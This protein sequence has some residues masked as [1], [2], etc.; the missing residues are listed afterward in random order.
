MGQIFSDIPQAIENSL[1][2][3]DK[4]STPSL[5]RDILLPIYQLPENFLVNALFSRWEQLLERVLPTAL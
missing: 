5:E 3:V 2:I 4:I 1:E